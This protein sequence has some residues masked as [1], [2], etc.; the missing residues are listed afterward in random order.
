MQ[1]FN[2]V[3]ANGINIKLEPGNHF[4]LVLPDGTALNCEQTQDD[5]SI[6][7]MNGVVAYTAATNKNL[8]EYEAE[9]SEI[10]QTTGR[11]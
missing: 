4:T 5:F 2:Q 6:V 11:G 3:A 8:P 9:R 10:L 1:F 7:R